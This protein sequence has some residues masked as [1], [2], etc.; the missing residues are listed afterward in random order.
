MAILIGPAALG[1]PMGI[2]FFPV[3]LTMLVIAVVL[4]VVGVVG[5]LIRR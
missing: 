1:V 3:G 4:G 5:S 2:L